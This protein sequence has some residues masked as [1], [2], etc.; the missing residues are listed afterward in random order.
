MALRNSIGNYSSFESMA[1]TSNSEGHG[2]SY[3]PYITP[4]R[5]N[6]V[7]VAQRLW[8]VSIGSKGSKRELLVLRSKALGPVG[9][10][11]RV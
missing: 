1:C 2:K 7:R 10:G 11:F 3:I 4:P 9:L 8:R 6:I 5:L